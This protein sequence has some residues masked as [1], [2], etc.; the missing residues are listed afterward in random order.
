MVRSA[1]PMTIT[2]LSVSALGLSNTGF[3][4]ACG[5]ARAASACRYC[6]R[7]ISSPSGVTAA[8]LLMFCALNGAARTPRLASSRHTPAARND[9]PASLVQPRS[10]RGRFTVGAGKWQLANGNWSWPVAICLLPVAIC[11]LLFVQHR[12]H[13]HPII[14]DPPLADVGHVV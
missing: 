10:M 4:R 8:L 5:V 6:A 12:L 13:R 11:Y 3:M 2:W 1:R 9:F 7:P 14:V